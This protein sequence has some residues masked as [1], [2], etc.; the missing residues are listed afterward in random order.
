MPASSRIAPRLRMARHVTKLRCR[1]RYHHRMPPVRGRL[2]RRLAP[3]L[4]ATAGLLAGLVA[5]STLA[6]APLASGSLAVEVTPVPLD[7][8][9]PSR[10]SVGPF[11]Y[12]GGLWL[13]AADPG[14]GGLSDLRVSADGER[15]VH[16]NQILSSCLRSLPSPL[17]AAI[18]G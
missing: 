12:M 3:L 17:L 11:E 6:G 14:F 16:G 18:Q 4:T 13:R 7:P 10:S 5:L 8:V 2:L 1:A 15:A 9:D